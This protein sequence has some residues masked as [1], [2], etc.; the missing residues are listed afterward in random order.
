MKARYD[1]TNS[2][3]TFAGVHY[4][5]KHTGKMKGVISV[6]TDINSNPFCQARQK[7]AGSICKMC[8]AEAMMDDEKGMYRRV[9]EAFKRNS[10]ILCSRL[11]TD[12]EIPAVDPAKFPL[13]RIQSF[14][15]IA[16][17]TEALNYLKMARKNPRV[18]FAFW[19][20]NIGI[21]AKAVKVAG[22]PTNM[23]VVF[24]SSFVNEETDASKYEFVDKVF[25]VYDDEHIAKGVDIN[26][27]AR[28]C[29]RC[30]RCYEPNPKGVKV[31]Q[32]RER[33]K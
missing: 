17:V 31:M 27:G 15:D 4:T 20:K 29:F 11:L 6:S 32:V 23:Q 14:G 26:C 9:N 7:V 16:N 12:A 22:K 2:R 25:S 21:L 30:R 3:N 10:E 19:T 8:Y 18:K 5:T 28:S 24:S 33:L 1:I 13:W